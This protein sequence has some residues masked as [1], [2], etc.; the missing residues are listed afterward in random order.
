MI[1]IGSI[2]AGKTAALGLP[3][4]NQD[5]HY[6]TF[7]INNFKRFYNDKNYVSEEIRGKLLNG[8]TVI[9]PSNDLCQKVLRLAK[10]HG[11]PDEAITYI[12]PTNPDTP[13]LN[14]LNGPVDK[15]AEM[16]AMVISGLSKD[17]DF[18]SINHSVHIL[19]ITYTC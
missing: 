11:I 6:M 5:L 8:I 2:G 13:S 1:I 9:E 16:F 10:A 3:L 7:M 17:A 18:F 14:I 12:D 4:I 15:V 19:K